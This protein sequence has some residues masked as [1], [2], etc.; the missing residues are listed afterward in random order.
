VE[1]LG[2]HNGT[3]VNGQR[4]TLGRAELGDRIRFGAVKCLLAS[5]PVSQPLEAASQSTFQVKSP[6]APTLDIASG[7][8]RTQQE[9]VGLLLEGLDEREIAARIGRQPSTVHTHLKAIYQHF[10]VKTRAKLIV[11]LL[12]ERKSRRLP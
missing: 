2:S 8:T 4:V 6:G 7:L 9:I 3:F 11:K 5:S 10:H 12:K 1:D